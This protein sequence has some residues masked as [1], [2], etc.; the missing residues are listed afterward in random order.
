[1]TIQIDDAGWGC[2]LL[3]VLIGAYRVETGEFAFGEIAVEHFQNE[4][5]LAR[6]TWTLQ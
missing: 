5:L 2:L 1:M 3:G 6:V 4:D